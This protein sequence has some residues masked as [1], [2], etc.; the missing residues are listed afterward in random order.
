MYGVQTT[1]YGVQTT[2]AK[3]SPRAA[4]QDSG[5]IPGPTVQSGWEKVCARVIPIQ[6]WLQRS[7]STGKFYFPVFALV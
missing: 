2:E 6:H 3:T 4:R 5:V 7:S 1:D